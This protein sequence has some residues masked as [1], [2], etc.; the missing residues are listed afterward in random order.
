MAMH[1]RRSLLIIF[2]G[3]NL[4]NQP[5]AHASMSAGIVG[6]LEA[7]GLVGDKWSFV[8]LAR[9]SGGE[10]MSELWAGRCMIM[11]E[12]HTGTIHTYTTALI[13]H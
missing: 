2:T 8:W 12:P 4:A 3:N 1:R 9:S 10:V 5:L 6:V 11:H 13:T 7:G